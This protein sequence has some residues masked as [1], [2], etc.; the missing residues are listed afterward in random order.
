M[1]G[2]ESKSDTNTHTHRAYKCSTRTHLDRFVKSMRD[3]RTILYAYCER[4]CGARSLMGSWMEWAKRAMR[5]RYTFPNQV[6]ITELFVELI[7]NTWIKYIFVREYACDDGNLF[8]LI[9]NFK[10]LNWIDECVRCVF[11][12]DYTRHMFVAYMHIQRRM[13]RMRNYPII[14]KSIYFL[15]PC[16]VWFYFCCTFSMNA[17][18][19]NCRIIHFWF[20]RWRVTITGSN[21]IKA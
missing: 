4:P 18:F 9:L 13:I 16:I 12:F 3:A 10:L 21:F 15:W 14:A 6:F 2:G 11:V 19:T 8:Y 17:M 5:R 7:Y 1:R 20:Y